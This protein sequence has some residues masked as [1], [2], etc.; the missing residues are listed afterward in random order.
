ML[1]LSCQQDY[2]SY[3]RQKARSSL[4]Q[5]EWSHSPHFHVIITPTPKRRPLEKE[6]SKLLL[7]C[8]KNQITKVIRALPWDL[9]LH[10]EKAIRKQNYDDLFVRYV[11]QIRWY[12]EI[13]LLNSS[14]LESPG[15]LWCVSH[16]GASVE[17]VRGWSLFKLAKWK[18]LKWLRS[19]YLWDRR[20]LLEYFEKPNAMIRLSFSNRNVSCKDIYAWAFC[21][22]LTFHICLCLPC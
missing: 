17:N 13:S 9:L 8:L 22:L 14:N 10:K 11:D 1:S 12:E 15:C 20:M 5:T 4:E 2:S 21:S 6:E 18:P 7:V 16:N 3:K 19:P